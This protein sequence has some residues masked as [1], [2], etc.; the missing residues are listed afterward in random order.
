MK[1][2]GH[3]YVPFA[4]LPGNEPPVAVEYE[5]GWA[6]ETFRVFLEKILSCPYRES[7][8]GPFSP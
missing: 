1:L 8:A 6:P 2:N 5:A 7:N 4:L 3:L